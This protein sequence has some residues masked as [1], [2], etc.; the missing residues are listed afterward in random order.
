MKFGSVEHPE[1]IDF[2]LPTDHPDTEVVLSK[3]KDDEIGRAH[4]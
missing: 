4:V 2:K 3:Y 1:L